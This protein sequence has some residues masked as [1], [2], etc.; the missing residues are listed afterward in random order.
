MLQSYLFYF[1]WNPHTLKLIDTKITFL[2]QL[3]PKLW[4]IYRNKVWNWRP[5]WIF[6]CFLSFYTHNNGLPCC[7]MCY[8]IPWPRKY[9]FRP[10]NHDP[11]W[12]NFRDIGKLRF[13]GG[14]FEKWLKIVVSPSFFLV[15]SL[16]W[17]LRV[18][19]TK[20]Y[21]SRRIMGGGGWGGVGG[22]GWGGV[23]LGGGVGVG[24]HGDPR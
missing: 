15:T 4:H 10:P 19:R 6:S 2:L 13:W 20:W 8:L 18:P 9:R 22:W 16:I 7:I 12:S 1:Y 23:G 21:H 14:H 5:S 11:T 24:V 17:F 3:E